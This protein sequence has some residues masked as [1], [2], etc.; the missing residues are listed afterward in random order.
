VE[1]QRVDPIVWTGLAEPSLEY[2]DLATDAG[3]RASATIVAVWDGLPIHLDY[4]I[5]CDPDWVVRRVDAQLAAGSDTRRLALRATR[6]GAWT[7]ESGRP[8]PVLDGCSYVDIQATPFTNSLPIRRLQLAP[9]GTRDVRVAYVR[10]PSLQVSAA[11]QRYTR[12]EDA[13]SPRYRYESGGFQ[14]ELVV[15][16]DG[17]VV[18]YERLWRRIAPAP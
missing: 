18:D 10:V 6:E 14:A 11:D 13:G 8:M 9:G 4:E 12:L 17:I 15:D 16:G 3:P 5:D 7:D 2:L 1:D